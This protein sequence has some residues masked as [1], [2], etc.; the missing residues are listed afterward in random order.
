MNNQLYLTKV[1]YIDVIFHKIRELLA[2][3]HILLE[4]GHNLDNIV[5][6]LTKLVTSEKFKLC[7]NL[8]YLFQC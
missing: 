8:L 4:K 7:I 1:K 5:D 3:E 2:F 6:M